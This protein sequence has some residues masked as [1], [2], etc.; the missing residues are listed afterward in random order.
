MRSS[1]FSCLLASALIL[2]SAPL[3][4]DHQTTGSDI[5]RMHKGGLKESTILEFIKTYCATVVL[6]GREIA[7]MAEAGFSDAFIR[8]ILDYMK[9]QP[10]EE[11]PPRN[12]QRTYSR[13]QSPDELDEPWR[14]SQSGDDGYTPS[15]SGS[16]Y[17]GYAFDP[18]VFPFWF[19]NDRHYHGYFPGG[20]GWSHFGGHYGAWGTGHTSGRGGF[21]HAYGGNGR[22]GHGGGHHGHR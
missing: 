12:S 13:T 3:W 22:Y 5:I 16:F 6:R 11:E 9:T 8:Q 10:P 17:V 7:D 2:G 20:H 19:Y 18:W 15:Y 1:L 14:D 21:G 4:A